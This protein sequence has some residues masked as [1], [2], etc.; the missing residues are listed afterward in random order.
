M[1]SELMEGV[2]ILQSRLSKIRK[3]VKKR[4]KKIETMDA[5]R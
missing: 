3:M 5:A 2:Q 4:T 1:R